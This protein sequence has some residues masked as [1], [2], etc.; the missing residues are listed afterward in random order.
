MHSL[1][2]GPLYF[3]LHRTVRVRN[4]NETSNLPPSLGN[5]E[6][7][8]VSDYK[9]CPKTWDKDACFIAMHSEE[10]MWISFQAVEPIAVIIGA[11]TINAL[12][13]KTFESKL[14]KD[15]YLV[16]PPQPWLDGW[17]GDDGSI[18]QFVATEIGGNK[19]I[20]EQLT[21]TKDHALVVSAF[22]A[23]NPD[24]LQTQVL[25]PNTLW[26]DSEA[27]DLCCVAF[28]GSCLKS[29][30]GNSLECYGLQQEAGDSDNLCNELGLGKGGKIKQK[31]YEDPHGIEEWEEKPIKTIKIYLINASEFAEITGQ[32]LPQPAVAE[33]YNGVWFG[34]D[35]K[36]HKETEGCSVF[37]KLKSA[38]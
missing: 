33:Q 24:K 27:G 17:K 25:T 31:I 10:A 22:K 9:N 13:G 12:N 18:Y 35:D 32:V 15:G 34:L 4:N 28:A 5:F 2:I 36:K 37:D 23:K 21:K 20:G 6:I 19:T 38:I 14:E 16:T 7:F 11:G 30:T 26:G 3:N 8:K 1:E 29:I